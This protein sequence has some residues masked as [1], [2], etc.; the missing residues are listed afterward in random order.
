MHSKKGTPFF[1]HHGPPKKALGGLAGI[2]SYILKRPE[3]LIQVFSRDTPPLAYGRFS[4]WIADPLL[5]G[6]YT[7]EQEETHRFE[8]HLCPRRE[9][10][11]ELLARSREFQSTGSWSEAFQKRGVGLS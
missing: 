6:M 8:G 4:E 11:D 1:E 2:T 9:E 7:E 5:V 3:G 10:M